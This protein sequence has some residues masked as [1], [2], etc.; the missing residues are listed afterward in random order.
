MA[1]IEITYRAA[2][3]SRTSDEDAQ[4]IGPELARLTAEGRNRA[5]DI[6]AAARPAAAPLHPY[7]EWDDS[8]AAEEWRKSQ[9]R[10]LARS[11]VVVHT[12][13]KGDDEYEIRA[14]YAVYVTS[15]DRSAREHRY[16]PFYEIRADPELRD[17]VIDAAWRAL[18][19]W[20]ER[21]DLYREE[22]EAR[23]LGPVF[24]AVEANGEREEAA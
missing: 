2:P 8:A 18:R 19:S 20:T 7:F 22:L 5:G 15:E 11:I 12:R 1:T 16:V 24:E 3:G 17:Q 9:A 4:V 14:F 21:Y 23:G 10:Q 13:D 6:V